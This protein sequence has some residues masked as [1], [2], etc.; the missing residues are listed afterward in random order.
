MSL[1]QES[2]GYGHTAPGKSWHS[3][4]V[5]DGDETRY[6]LWETKLLAHLSLLKLKKQV[7]GDEKAEAHKNEEAY[8]VIAQLLDDR[9]LSLVMR[10]GKDNGRKALAI[11]REHYAGRGKPRMIS[12]YTMLMSLQ[13]SNEESVTDYIIRTE[14]AVN[15]L[16]NAGQTLE[17]SMIVALVMKGLPREYKPFVVVMMQSDRTMS[18]S[19]FKVALRSFEESEKAT[20]PRNDHKIMHA[21]FRK[22]NLGKGRGGHQQH[23]GNRQQQGHHQNNQNGNGNGNGGFAKKKL[24]CFNCNQEGH[25][26]EACPIPPRQTQQR[27][28]GGPQ[29]MWCSVCRSSTHTDKSCRK[30]N[31]GRGDTAKR[32]QFEPVSDEIHSF[33]F[34]YHCRVVEETPVVVEEKEAPPVVDVGY[35]IDRDEQL[36]LAINNERCDESD[37]RAQLLLAINNDRCDESVDDEVHQE[38][39]EFHYPTTV[40][41]LQSVADDVEVEDETVGEDRVETIVE[42]R[43]ETIGEDLSL[44][45]I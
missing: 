23:Q 18:F 20:N 12:Q 44:I 5:F 6:E 42:D 30:Q 14:S 8:A 17:D 29:K 39:S 4:L 31:G 28:N 10:D 35:E 43:V 33:D 11:L 27:N 15:A 26:R 45:H 41:Y 7:L 13:K 22:M 21:G 25:K 3:A 16:K 40:A 36:L 2:K 24:I 38:E 1:S 19:E 37:V 9:S 32:V 34:G